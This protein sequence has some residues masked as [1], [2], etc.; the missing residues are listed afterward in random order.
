MSATLIPGWSAVRIEGG[1]K[2]PSNNAADEG[3][4]W[5]FAADLGVI[6]TTGVTAVWETPSTP[7]RS[8][9]TVTG[10]S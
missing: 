3:K 6:R 8:S 2:T 7:R 4:P 10:R 5:S 1:A 9:M